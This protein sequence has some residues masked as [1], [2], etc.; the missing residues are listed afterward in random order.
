MVLNDSKM[1]HRRI[2][3]QMRFKALTPH[4]VSGFV[5]KVQHF[6]KTHPDI[7]QNE[8]VSAFLVSISPYGIVLDIKAYTKTIDTLKFLGVKQNILLKIF[9]LRDQN[10]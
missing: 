7:D 4:Q 9:E 1:T 8:E 10:S 6:L 5:Q 3:E 2:D